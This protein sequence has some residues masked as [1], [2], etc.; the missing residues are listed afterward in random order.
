MSRSSQENFLSVAEAANKLQL[1]RNTVKRRVESGHLQG[2][3][4][5]GSGFWYITAK[6]VQDLLREQ[7]KLQRQATLGK[8]KN[9]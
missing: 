5:P 8:G 7:T 2:Y 1:S 9:S 4:D 6:S 3:A